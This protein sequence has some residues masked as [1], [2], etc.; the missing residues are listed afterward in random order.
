[1]QKNILYIS[2]DGMTDPLGQSQVLPYI[3][4]LSQK[5]YR[6]TLLSCEKPERYEM[7]KAIIEKICLENH[8][9]WQPIMYTKRPPVL[10]TIW[11]VISLQRRAYKLHSQKKFDLT[12]CRGYISSLIGLSLKRK[13]RVPFLFDMRGF[14]AD[15]RID[16]GIWNIKNPFYYA[17]YNFF[18]RKEIS[19]FNES[20]ITIS[21]TEIGKQEI[22]SWRTIKEEIE[23]EVIPCCADMNLFDYRNISNEEKQF[24]LKKYNIKYD[25]YTLIYI[26]NFSTVYNFNEVLKVYKTIKN[27]NLKFIV[28][29]HEPY[30]IYRN[31][32]MNNN[33]ENDNQI[34]YDSLSRN[35]IPK[36]LSIADY[37]IFF[38]KEGFSRKATSPTRLAEILGCGLKVV[39]NSGIGDTKELIENNNLG[40]VFN[41][42]REDEF[43]RFKEFFKYEKNYD[44]KAIHTI[45]YNNFDVKYGI[46]KYCSVY[47][48]ILNYDSSNN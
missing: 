28:C 11:D 17:V 4:G 5:G 38:C 37:S 32:L 3:C 39:I 15:E 44:K 21:L 12:H 33:L 41:N 13:K 2:Y 25:D 47:N 14:W 23:I 31:F 22:K 18:K 36:V 16:G 48:K 24:Y 26:G 43:I 10:S 20:A 34:I 45:S 8:I 6:Y 1:M 42:F 29:S 35:E 30:N 19:F 9:D 7:N 27:N 40:F 46:D